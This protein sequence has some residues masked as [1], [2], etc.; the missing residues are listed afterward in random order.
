MPMTI[1]ESWKARNA[2][3]SRIKTY[4]QAHAVWKYSRDVCGSSLEGGKH[5][6][7]RNFIAATRQYPLVQPYWSRTYVGMLPPASNA[8]DLDA[9]MYTS[10]DQVP[11]G[12][13]AFYYAPSHC[14]LVNSIELV[15]WYPD[16]R[17]VVHPTVGETY[18]WG[19]RERA[20]AFGDFH[21]SRAHGEIMVTTAPHRSGIWKQVRKPITSSTGK[22]LTEIIAADGSKTGEYLSWERNYSRLYFWNSH[23]P[24]IIPK[25][26]RQRPYLLRGVIDAPHA[27]QGENTEDIPRLQ[28]W[29]EAKR[30]AK[31]QQKLVRKINGLM[32]SLQNKPDM[33]RMM[34]RRFRNELGLQNAVEEVVRSHAPAAPRVVTPPSVEFLGAGTRHDRRLILE[35]Q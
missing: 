12:R 16:G 33:L 1:K 3:P 31:Y 5:Y 29:C 20:E 30:A 19:R 17:C 13:I 10:N 2:I 15:L 8:S 25:N 7:S 4:E 9:R 23:V 18:Q 22:Y 24:M 32:H 35:D 21:L 6:T 26:R 27:L 14:R 28:S 11:T 34:S